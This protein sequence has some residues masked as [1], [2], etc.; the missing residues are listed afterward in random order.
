MKK[1]FQTKKGRLTKREF[2]LQECDDSWGFENSPL[3]IN[4]KMPLWE[5]LL[6]A[7]ILGYFAYYVYQAITYII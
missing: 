6:Y 7:G 3:S 4:N 1:D 2:D 5:K